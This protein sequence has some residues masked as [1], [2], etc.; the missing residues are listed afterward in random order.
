ML[1]SDASFKNGR[2]TTCTISQIYSINKNGF[3]HNML[4]IFFSRIVFLLELRTSKYHFLEITYTSEVTNILNV[5]NDKF[6]ELQARFREFYISFCPFKS[7]RLLKTTQSR[8]HNE[9]LVEASI[10]SHISYFGSLLL[11]YVIRK[12][13]FL[14]QV[15]I[16]LINQ[17]IITL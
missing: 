8:N 16:I 3:L 6:P 10:F 4:L 7:C 1:L 15:S 9:T 17:L 12:A 2:A 13:H 14:Q 11:W 5:T